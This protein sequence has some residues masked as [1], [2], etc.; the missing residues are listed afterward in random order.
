M[1]T[2]ALSASLKWLTVRDGSRK[3][4]RMVR[5][6]QAALGRGHS[7]SGTAHT[8]LPQQALHSSSRPFGSGQLWPQAHRRGLDV[9]FGPLTF[10]GL[11][12]SVFSRFLLRE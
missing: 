4:M 1:P 12:T 2:L 5:R 9:L 11:S 3:K 10:A 7:G 8:G 6:L